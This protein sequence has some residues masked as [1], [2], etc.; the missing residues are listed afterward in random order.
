MWPGRGYNTF[1][2]PIELLLGYQTM[3]LEY[4]TGS[5]NRKLV[6]DMTIFGPQLGIRF[7]F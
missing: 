7:H 2:G 5:G 3:G 6:Y 1:L 4:T